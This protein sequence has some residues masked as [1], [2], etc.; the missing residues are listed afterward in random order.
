MK[1]NFAFLELCFE[2]LEEEEN[3]YQWIESWRS[4]PRD[5][6]RYRSFLSLDCVIKKVRVGRRAFFI[7][8]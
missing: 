5:E 8:L 2:Y 4:V 3:S 1:E 7:S 6:A